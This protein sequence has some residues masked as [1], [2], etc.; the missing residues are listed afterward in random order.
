MRQ[1][2]ISPLRALV[3]SYVGMIGIAVAVNTPPVCLTAVAEVF[4]LTDTQRG[5]LLG[6]LF[7]GFAV[8]ILITGPLGD[9][10]GYKPFLLAASALQVAG[11]GLSSLASSYSRLLTGALLTGVGSGVLEVLVSPLVCALR[12]E[13]RTRAMNLC[14]GFY[15]IGAVGTLVAG[16]WLLKAGVSWR[17]VYGVMILPPLVYGMGYLTSRLPGDNRNHSINRQT[18]TFP[19]RRGVFWL[20]LAVMLLIAGTEI[21]PAQW[22]PAYLEEVFTFRR[23]LAPLGLLL[24]SGAMALGRF[25]MSHLSSRYLPLPLLIVDCV[26]C[27]ACL[28][29]VAATHSRVAAVA[30]FTCLGMFVA[31]FWPTVL[32]YC[33]D[34]IPDGGI[35][36]FGAL[37]AVGNSA[38]ILFPTLVGWGADQMGLRPALGSLFL[39]PLL[40]GLLF[41]WENLRSSHPSQNH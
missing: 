36:M 26:A 24:F 41:A 14:H 8:A 7:W 31:P 37:S 23:D 27:A 29:V 2:N 12:P 40:A 33:A 25:A 6:A 19:W 3:S 30:A 35:T 15:S 10:F 5:V 11:L 18:V 20:M 38:G 4:G 34:R 22:I 1:S 13:A 16:M 39:L 21:G 28:G 17:V 32:A 9:R